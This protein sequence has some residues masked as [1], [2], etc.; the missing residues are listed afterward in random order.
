MTDEV[1]EA[2]WLL[3]SK[4]HLVRLQQ[5]PW[6]TAREA[7]T[8]QLGIAAI[9]TLLGDSPVQDLTAEKESI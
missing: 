5:E 2:S 9:N 8:V 1:R 6:L 4:E 3:N 7:A